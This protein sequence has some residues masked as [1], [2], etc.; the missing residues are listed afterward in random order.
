M[1]APSD[2]EFPSS[3]PAGPP[4]GLDVPSRTALRRGLL[5]EA[6]IAVVVLGVTAVLVGSPRAAETYAPAVTTTE[7]SGGLALTARVDAAHT[8]QTAVH[9][10]GADTGGRAVPVSVVEASLTLPAQGI[11]PLPVVAAPDVAGQ[12]TAPL[13]FA[14]PGDWALDVTVASPVGPPTLF[15]VVVPVR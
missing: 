13:S 7:H 3:E 9:L 12:V 4:P 14:V 10:S 8:G 5:A 2:S 15:R 11:G 6:A 1:L